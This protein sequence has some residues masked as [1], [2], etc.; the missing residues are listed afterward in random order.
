MGASAGGLESLTAVV[1]RLPAD[2]QA[3]VVIGMHVSPSRRS[4]LTEILGRRGPLPVT[5]IEGR[6][7]LEPGRIYVVPANWNVRIVDGHA[8][9]SEEHTSELQSREK[10]TTAS[11]HDALPISPGCRPISR[12]RSSSACM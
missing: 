6:T 11:L 4:S 9:R 2:F 7:P 10:L 12:R 8:E 1:S 5:N 3:P